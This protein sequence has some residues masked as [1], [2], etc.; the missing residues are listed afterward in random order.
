[1]PVWAERGD[2]TGDFRHSWDGSEKL[3]DQTGW[4]ARAERSSGTKFQGLNRRGSASTIQVA[5]ALNGEAGSWSVEIS[6]W[7][8]RK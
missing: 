3:P 4:F 5:D 7:L 8:G 2:G 1:M 6:T